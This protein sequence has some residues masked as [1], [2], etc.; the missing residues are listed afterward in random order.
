MQ[1]FWVFAACLMWSFAESIRYGN[2]F[3]SDVFGNFEWVTWLRYSGFILLYPIGIS[4]EML[5]LLE[6]FP[7]IEKCCPRVLSVEMP[8][9]FNFAFDYLYFIW[10]AVIP[11]Y[12]VGSPFLYTYMMEQRKKKLQK[13]KTA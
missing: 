8:N 1:S 9:S 5:S 3:V 7:V 6:A 4:S 2:Y 11:G 10:L 13:A 12:L